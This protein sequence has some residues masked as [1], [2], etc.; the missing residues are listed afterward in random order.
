MKT[1]DNRNTWRKG[2]LIATLCSKNPT[3]TSL[4]MN[5]SPATKNSENGASI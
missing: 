2:C 3:W 5:P 1:E 4:E